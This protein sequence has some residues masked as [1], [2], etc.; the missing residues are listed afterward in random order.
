MFAE[1]FAAYAAHIYAPLNDEP[2]A[3]TALEVGYNE[4][5]AGILFMRTS[6]EFDSIRSSPRFRDL[7]RRMGF[8]P[9]PSDKN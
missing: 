4:R 2:R 5:A 9:S 3:M 6:P 8:P 1:A 7:V